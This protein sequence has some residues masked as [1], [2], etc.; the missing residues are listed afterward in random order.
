MLL[1]LSRQRTAHRRRTSPPVGESSRT[2]KVADILPGIRPFCVEM[3]NAV[4]TI[5]RIWAD[6]T[7][8]Y[9]YRS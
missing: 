5:D 7:I 9:S 1:L 3:R 8:R 6:W 2:D 4:N